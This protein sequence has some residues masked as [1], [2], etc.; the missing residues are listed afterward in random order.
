MTLAIYM[1]FVTINVATVITMFIFTYKNIFKTSDTLSEF[2]E[3]LG[4]YDDDVTILFIG[5][6]FFSILGPV[7]TVVLAFILFACCV[8]NMFK[9]LVK[10]VK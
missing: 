6:L 3:N 2:I 10:H 8:Y 4:R 7:L 5:S 9:Y 1:L